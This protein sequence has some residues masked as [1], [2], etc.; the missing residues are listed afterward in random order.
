M[1]VTHIRDVQRMVVLDLGLLNKTLRNLTGTSTTS[2]F[3]YRGSEATPHDRL[4]SRALIYIEQIIAAAPAMDI[5]DVIDLLLNKAYATHYIDSTFS[6]AVKTAFYAAIYWNSSGTWAA[7]VSTTNA[8]DIGVYGIFMGFLKGI[9]AIE[10]T[11]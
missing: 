1:Y 3:A 8:I 5:T 6:A 9:N 11:S 4:I 2:I 7:S 10:I